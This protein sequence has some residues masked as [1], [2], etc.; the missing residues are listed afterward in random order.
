VDNPTWPDP[1]APTIGHHCPAEWTYPDPRHARAINEFIWCLRSL[2]VWVGDPSFEELRRRSGV[3]AS[4]LA[5]ATN[6]GRARLP[7][8]AT[9]R[10]FVR[11]CGVTTGLAQWE[12]AWRTVQHLQRAASDTPVRL[13][14]RPDQLPPAARHFVGRRD[15]LCRLDEVVHT[16]RDTRCWAPVVNLAG[17]AGAGKT[18]A[19]VLWARQNVPTYPDGRLFVNLYGSV[20]GAAD[21]TGHDALRMLLTALG[22]DE[23]DVP[24]DPTVRL[25]LYRSLIE[26][27]QC[28]VMLDDADSHEQVRPLLPGGPK[29]LT[30]VTS[31]RPLARLVTHQDAVVLPLEPLE[32]TE[33]VRLLGLL[34]GEERVAREHA[35]AHQ[36]LQRCGYLPLSIREAAAYLVEAPHRSL[37]EYVRQPLRPCGEVG[38]QLPRSQVTV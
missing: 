8:L 26:P 3:P 7:R 31:R 18:A 30:L 29:S 38:R 35:A 21:I 11:A 10:A 5:D 17:P 22:I 34:I 25:G 19:A 16:H 23:P 1:D 15:L 20:G 36:L 32:P 28:L 2:K 6:P 33:A 37:A 9:V 4:T 27:R 14:G 13:P 24:A 12:Q